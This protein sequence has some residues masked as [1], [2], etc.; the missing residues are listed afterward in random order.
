MEGHTPRSRRSRGVAVIVGF[1]L[2]ATLVAFGLAFTNAASARRV[3]ETSQ[4]LQWANATSGSMALGRA[5]LFQAVVFSVD[6]RLGVATQEAEALALAEA[7]ST[8]DAFGGWIEAAP[9]IEEGL[10]GA[11]WSLHDLGEDVV[12]LLSRGDVA[13]GDRVLTRDFEAEYSATTAKLADVQES[14][15]ATI[16]KAETDAGRIERLT[17]LLVTLLIPLAAI[18]LYRLIARRQYREHRVQMDAKLEAERE[19]NRSKDRFIAGLSH[20]LRTPLT[21]IYG[22]SEYLLD[23]GLI[24]PDE[25]IELI[26]MI[27]HDSA[28]LTRM[29]EDLLAA[30]RLEAGTLHLDPDDV[31]LGSVATA[32]AERLREEG[33]RL[34]IDGAAPRAWADPDGVAHI[35]R[36]LCSNA[37]RY[38]GEHK[39]IIVSGDGRWSS[40]A[41]VDNGPGVPDELAG[42]MFDRF[43]NE[44]ERTLLNGSLGL[45]L[46]VA[47]GIAR[48]M[49]GSLDYEHSNGRTTFLVRLP[50][51]APEDVEKTRDAS[52]AAIGEMMAV[53]GPP[54]SPSTSIDEPAPHPADSGTHA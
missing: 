30:A 13:E 34:R 29:V 3:A 7:A 48:H 18:A 28:E 9:A 4:Q 49:G 35:V 42:R 20:E 44:G 11:L 16:S 46:S 45:G 41:V 19:L 24:D 47:H 50:G 5:A 52:P 1:S 37:I 40:I 17:Q 27:N 33:L 54:T 26:G 39:E 32:A 23:E 43:L 53:L 12:D 6:A 38:G 2:V 8:L 15:G 10:A 21:S 25:A 22:F 31:D 36:N 51:A 14:F